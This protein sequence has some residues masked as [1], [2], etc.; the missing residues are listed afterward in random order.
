VRIQVSHE[1]IA[2]GGESL[3]ASGVSD[4]GLIGKLMRLK[5]AAVNIRRPTAQGWPEATSNRLIN[6]IFLSKSQSG[7]CDFDEPDHLAIKMVGLQ[8]D[9][10]YVVRDEYPGYLG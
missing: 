6:L 5:S 4:W 3:D 2:D 8:G 10:G 9:I 1:G 7:Q